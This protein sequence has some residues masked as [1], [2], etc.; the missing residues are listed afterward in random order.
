MCDV[1]EYFR[2]LSRDAG[3]SERITWSGFVPDPQLLSLLSKASVCIFPSRYEG[4]GYTLVEALAAGCICA[5]NDIPS[6]RSIIQDAGNGYLINFSHAESS[7]R[8]LNELLSEPREILENV[9]LNARD[10]ARKYDWES[11]IDQLI[12]VYKHEA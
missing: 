10:S 5:A 6:Y 3:I 9:S 12:E 2:K 11:K 4:F 8:R 7:A 1:L